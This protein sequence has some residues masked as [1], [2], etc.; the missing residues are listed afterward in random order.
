MTSGVGPAARPLP[1]PAPLLRRLAAMVYEAVLLF[2]VVMIAGIAYS[3]L[4]QQR[5]ALQ[6]TLGLQLVLFAALGLYFAYFWSH[7]G[8]TLPMKT[9]RIGVMS[10]D[11]A[12]LSFGRALARYA[13]SWLWFMPALASLGM[14]GVRGAGAA[15]A[16]IAAGMAAY[17]LLARLRRD[18]QYLHDVVCGTQL[19]DLRPGVGEPA[20]S[21]A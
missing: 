1:R 7:G 3:V 19:V 8:Q 6:G 10:R 12:G 16:V 17:L 14:S 5:H 4:T 21:P 9:W 11:G 2:G 13:L 15:F 20:Q 18:R